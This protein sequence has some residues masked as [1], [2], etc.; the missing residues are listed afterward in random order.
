MAIFSGKRYFNDILW[1]QAYNNNTLLLVK[2]MVICAF[3]NSPSIPSFLATQIVYI[4]YGQFNK[5]MTPFPF[6]FL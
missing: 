1:A 2:Y 5:K 4:R 6:T 3:E